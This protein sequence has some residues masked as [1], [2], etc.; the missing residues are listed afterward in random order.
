[1]SA[2]P[3]V[4]CGLEFAA[5]LEGEKYVLSVALQPELSEG[6]SV[7]VAVAAVVVSVDAGACD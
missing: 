4:V 5:F 3:L 2:S 7:L 1:M 6:V